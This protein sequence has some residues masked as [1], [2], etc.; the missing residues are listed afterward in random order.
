MFDEN[1]HLNYF[2]IF[3][4]TKRLKHKSLLKYL[5]NLFSF[6]SDFVDSITVKFRIY[7]NNNG[8]GIDFFQV[9]L[10]SFSKTYFHN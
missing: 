3:Y 8:E 4:S 7:N 1:I 5:K 2:H 10:S 6:F 9:E